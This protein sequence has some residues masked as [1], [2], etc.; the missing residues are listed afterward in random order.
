MQRLVF[1]IFFFKSYRRKTFWGV[2][3]TPG[4]LGKQNLALEN[5]EHPIPFTLQRIHKSWRTVDRYCAVISC[6]IFFTFDKIFKTS[7]KSHVCMY[8]LIQSSDLELWS[9]PGESLNSDALRTEFPDHLVTLHQ[10]C[11]YRTS[12]NRGS[13]CK[14]YQYTCKHRWYIEVSNKLNDFTKLHSF[15]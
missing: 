10:Q 15:A 12:K 14:G 8:I 2:D 4:P 6:H 3:S 5:V 7:Q 13:H 9:R 11:S 1:L